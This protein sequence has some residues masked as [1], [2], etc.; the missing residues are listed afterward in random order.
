[1]ASLVSWV[2]SLDYTGSFPLRSLLISFAFRPRE[3]GDYV[4]D[5]G[6]MMQGSA[7]GSVMR[8]LCLLDVMRYSILGGDEFRLTSRYLSDSYRYTGLSPQSQAPSNK[9]HSSS[10]IP[11]FHALAE[12]PLLFPVAASLDYLPRSFEWSTYP[13]LKQLYKPS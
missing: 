8:F 11:N 6:V 9:R 13:W 5:G 3:G 10:L 12:T 4:D 7:E 1:M 2:S